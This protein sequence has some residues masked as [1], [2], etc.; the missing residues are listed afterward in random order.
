MQEKGN[1]GNWMQI[2]YSAP[3]TGNSF[4]YASNVFEYST[5]DASL[6]DTNYD[7]MADPKVALN[8][9]AAAEPQTGSWK[10]TA[11]GT[12][13]LTITDGSGSNNCK[14]LTASWESLLRN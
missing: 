7:W 6:D 5:T 13:S 2:G 4:S 14:A 9:C 12:S 10:L 11:G 8:D 3:G 1:A